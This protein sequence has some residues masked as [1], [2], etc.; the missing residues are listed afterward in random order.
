MCGAIS[1]LDEPGIYVAAYRL[2]SH[3]STP[4]KARD[5][6]ASVGVCMGQG[7]MYL[8]LPWLTLCDGHTRFRVSLQIMGR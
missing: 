1:S 8:S 7:Q 2:E 3:S 4:A 6:R 5:G